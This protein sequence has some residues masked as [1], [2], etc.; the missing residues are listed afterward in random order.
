MRPLNTE[1]VTDRPSLGDRR[2][3]P[4]AA[5]RRIGRHLRDRLGPESITWSQTRRE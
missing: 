1:I 4:L 5:D 2:F 3:E